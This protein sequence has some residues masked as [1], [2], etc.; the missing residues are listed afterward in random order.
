LETK[1]SDVELVT[2]IAL[3]DERAMRALYERHKGMVGRLA[4]ASAAS[5]ADAREL[6]QDTFVRAWRAAGSFRGES[7]VA[8]WLRGIARH[9]MADYVH[10]QIRARKVFSQ[11][12]PED[13]APAIA[14]ADPGPERMA[15][16][17]AAKRCIDQCLR[18]LTPAHREVLVLRVCGALPCRWVR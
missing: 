11:S 3:G 18:Q 5:D 10:I 4:R 2:R 13:D 8:S 16:L 17:A 1:D 12:T 9:L 14:S 6:V 15:E 7:S